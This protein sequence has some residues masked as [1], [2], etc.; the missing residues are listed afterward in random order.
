MKQILD[1]YTAIAIC[2][3]QYVG[4]CVILLAVTIINLPSFMFR[5]KGE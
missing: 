5:R 2:F 1:D 4:L 3:V